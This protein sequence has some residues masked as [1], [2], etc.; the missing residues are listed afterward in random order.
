MVNDIG[1]KVVLLFPS[2]PTFFVLFL[3]FSYFFLKK[4][5]YSYFFAVKCQNDDWSQ[6]KLRYR[7]I[8]AVT[9]ELLGAFTII[10]S[11]KSF[12]LYFHHSV[13]GNIIWQHF[14]WKIHTIWSQTCVKLFLLYSYFSSSDS[15]FFLET[16]P[17]FFLL[18][19]QKPLS[20]LM[21]V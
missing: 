16:I 3:L 4:S 12:L 18:F 7:E 14:C 15:Y 21:T 13:Y 1:L 17:T 10:L 6:R 5:Y 19:H 8:T 2:F 9:L 11:K 20:S